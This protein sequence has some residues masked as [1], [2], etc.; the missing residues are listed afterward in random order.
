MLYFVLIA[1]VNGEKQFATQ[2]L[3]F[4]QL[5]IDNINQREVNR[6]VDK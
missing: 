3:E 6:Y 2:V 4:L 5:A 1:L